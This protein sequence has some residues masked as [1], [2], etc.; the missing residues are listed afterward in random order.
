MLDDLP[1]MDDAP[2]R[3][4]R[5]AC[6]VAFG[7]ATTILGA[8]AL[9]GMAFGLVAGDARLSP[10]QRLE[11]ATLLGRVTGPDGMPGG[12][13][14]ELHPSA[15]QQ[16]LAAIERL[17]AAKTGVLFEAAAL[18][19]TI[20]AGITGPRSALMADFGMRLGLAFQALDDIA[21]APPADAQ[22]RDAGP[23]A[24]PASVVDLIGAKDAAARAEMHLL[25]ALECLTAS[26][27]ARNDLAG[28][29]EV[30]VASMRQKPAAA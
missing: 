27:A 6:H 8:V 21:D 22:R 7:E 26:G 18:A 1:V 4:G 14:A 25:V 28:Y 24:G 9:I 10:T 15:L 2:V 5:P 23:V 16:P 19:G 29:V 13:D 3:R 17:H 20:A 12:Q 30:L 11:L